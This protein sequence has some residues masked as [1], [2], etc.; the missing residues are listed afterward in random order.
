MLSLPPRLIKKL[1]LKK[2]SSRR[3]RTAK[4]TA[5]FNIYDA[6]RLTIQGRVCTIDVSEVAKDCPALIGQVPQD[7]LDFV[8][9]PTG[10]R[11]IGNPEHGGKFMHDMY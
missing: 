8:V 3:M 5:N 6:V 10:Q 11:L 4:G 7:L 1:G 9:D 2:F